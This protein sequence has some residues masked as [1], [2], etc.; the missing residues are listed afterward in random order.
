MLY[1]SVF[2]NSYKSLENVIYINPVMQLHSV[3]GWLGLATKLTWLGLGKD[4]GLG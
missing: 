3:K 1:R 2:L 4:Q